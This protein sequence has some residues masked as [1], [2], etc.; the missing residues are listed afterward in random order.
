MS[1]HNLGHPHLD[2]MVV[3]ETGRRPPVVDW[4]NFPFSGDL[5]IKPFEQ[6]ELP[7]PPRHGAAGPAECHS[8]RQPDSDYLWVDDNWRVSTTAEPPGLPAIVFLHPRAHHDLGDLTP[9]LVAELGS[10]IFRVERAY[11]AIGGIA[12]VHMARWGDGGAHLHL[13]FYGRPEGFV[14]ARGTWLATWDDI[15]PPQPEAQWRENLRRFA[16]AL[17]AGGGRLPTAME[18]SGSDTTAT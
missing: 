17:L 2:Q 16:E 18:R 13:W 11:T 1:A 15:L 8:C 12:R 10:M 3:G 7:E 9:Q 6:P 14:Q 5:V 4:N